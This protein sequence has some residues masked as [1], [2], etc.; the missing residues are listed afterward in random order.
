L[1]LVANKTGQ[2]TSQRGQASPFFAFFKWV[3]KHF[4][5]PA[6]GYLSHLRPDLTPARREKLGFR[7][8]F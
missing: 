1:T 2:M 8:G 4:L 6:I 3:D 7:P 5:S